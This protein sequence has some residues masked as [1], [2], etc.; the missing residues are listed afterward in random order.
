MKIKEMEERSGMTRANIRFYESEGLLSPERGINGYREYSEEDL[1]V[2][3]RIKLLRS[4]HIT[5]EEIKELHNGSL[6]LSAAL[7]LHLTRLEAEKEDLEH[8]Q[9]IW[10]A[11]YRLRREA[12][13]LF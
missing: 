6:E 8:S 4:L 7:D 5:L 11:H 2:L 13:N 12:A 10:L 3:M 1:Q 9:E